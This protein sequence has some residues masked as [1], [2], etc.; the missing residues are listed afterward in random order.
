[1]GMTENIELYPRL[2]VDGADA[3]LAFYATAFGGTVSERFTDPTG[4][5][6]HAMVAAGPVRF[7]VKDADGCD[8]SPV[9]GAVPVIVALHVPDADA[10]AAHG[11]AVVLPLV[12]RRRTRRQPG[13]TW[14][15]AVGRRWPGGSV[16][17]TPSTGCPR[18]ARRS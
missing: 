10:V 16:S 11:A 3:A 8:P 18:S 13:R 9:D 4:R 5:V 6:V 7:A 17:R 12:T 14:V 15:R 2:V 1:M